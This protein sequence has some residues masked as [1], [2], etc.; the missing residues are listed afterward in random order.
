[1]WIWFEFGDVVGEVFLNLIYGQDWYLVML[2]D[3]ILCFMCNYDFVIFM[4]GMVWKVYV[5]Q[6]NG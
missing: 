2:N 3:K 5:V 6:V 1:M 4:F